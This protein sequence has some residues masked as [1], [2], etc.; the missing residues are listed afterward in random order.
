MTPLLQFIDTHVNKPC[1][2]LNDDEVDFEDGE[3]NDIDTDESD[4]ELT[5]EA[6][7]GGEEDDVD[8]EVEGTDDKICVD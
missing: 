2:Y 3:D 5:W 8:K 1:K 7:N 6:D 4:D